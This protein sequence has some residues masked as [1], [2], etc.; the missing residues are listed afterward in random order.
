VSANPRPVLWGVLNVTPDS[1]SDGGVFLEQQAAVTHARALV[2]A[3]A[4][5]IDIGG[6][7]TRPGAPRVAPAI[8]QERV[9]P[10]IHALKDEGFTL[11]IDTMNSSTAA[12]AIAEGVAYVNDVSGGLADPEMLSVVAA[13]SVD[14]VMMHWR[15]HSDQMDSLAT[16][17]DVGREVAVELQERLENAQ[18]AGI[19]P[20]R[21][22]L[23]PGVGFAKTPHHNWQLL[24]DLGQIVRLGHRVLVGASRKRF[25]G[26]LLPAGHQPA[27]R[28]G[29]SATL[30]ALLAE[31]GVWGLRVHNPLVHREALDVWQSLSQGGLA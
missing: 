25:L 6:E 12:A 15:G 13:S 9:L 14:Y 7:S 16:Y 8:E 20:Q 24:S 23:D 22:I 10:V 30:G 4:D 5:V 21:I 11:S 27:D 28:D 31:Q 19:A 3:G 17:Q 2:D 1:F 18:A 29:V 26:E